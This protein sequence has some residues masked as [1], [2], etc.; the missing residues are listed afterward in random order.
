[1]YHFYYVAFYNNKNCCHSLSN[2]N[3]LVTNADIVSWQRENSIERRTE[4]Q[5]KKPKKV[6]FEEIIQTVKLIIDFQSL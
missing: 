2:V 5:P 4:R 6:A 1:M 3:V